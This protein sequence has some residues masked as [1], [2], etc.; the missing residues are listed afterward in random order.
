MQ[1]FYESATNKFI[2]K[3]NN[4]NK[5]TAKDY[6]TMQRMGKIPPIRNFSILYWKGGEGKSSLKGLC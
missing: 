4:K 1:L 5:I 3:K 2:A 6:G